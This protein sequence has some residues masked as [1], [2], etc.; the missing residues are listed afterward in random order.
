MAVSISAC[1]SREDPAGGGALAPVD[2]AA[3]LAAL[4]LSRPSLAE[5]RS[6]VDG[7]D[8][9]RVTAALAAYVRARAAAW[10][11]DA[12][13]VPVGAAAAEVLAEA[14]RVARGEVE[15]VGVRH[16]F[17]GA[18]IDWSFN[19]TRDRDGVAFNRQW[20]NHLNRTRFW[21]PLAAAY[22]ATG[23]ERFAAAWAAQL[24]DFLADN[25][26]D[27][28]SDP[29]VRPAW[30]TL[31]TASRMK[32][33]WA[34]LLHAFRDSPSVTDEDLVGALRSFLEHGRHLRANHDGGLDNH[35]AVE[36]RGLHAVGC[37]FPDFRESEDWR[38]HAIATSAA[39]VG[40][41]F[42]PD[43]LSKELSPG[44][45]LLSLEEFWTIVVMSRRFGFEREVDE[46][47]VAALAPAVE[48]TIR[49]S[50]PERTLPSLND[51]GTPDVVAALA[52]KVGVFSCDDALRWLVSDG[53]EG[54]PPSTAS[55]EFD[56]AGLAV[57]RS[58]WAR[59]ATYA[60]F[61]V[62]PLGTDHVH[63]DKLNLVLWAYGRELLFDNGGGSYE[64]S[65]WREF[66]AD[67]R[68][69][70]AALVDGL[71]QRRAR[72]E[73]GDRVSTAPIDA[74]WEAWPDGAVARASYVGEWGD[75]PRADLRPDGLA[76]AEHSREVRYHAPDV[77]VVIDDLR[78]VDGAAHSYEL[79]WNLLST[80]VVVDETTGAVAT[81]DAGLPNLLVVPLGAERPAVTSV[82][83]R[84]GASWRDLA[85]WDLGKRGEPPRPAT[86]VL[87]A[88]EGPGPKRFVTV[89]LALA[90]GTSHEGRVVVDAGAVRVTGAG[91]S[92]TIEVTAAGVDVRR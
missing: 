20:G 43:G 73:K 28:A 63:Q 77:F 50:T 48:A 56:W 46:G 3:L 30:K 1:S 51:S 36:M 16:A 21:R 61:D 69:H 2:D 68:S 90:P 14:D 23:D 29:K 24:R 4:D 52:D 55:H 80:D 42:Y 22:L 41:I 67:T 7:G 38:R 26:F 62:G 47:F 44:Y 74:R 57:M 45:H 66:G 13:E 32:N 70:N 84:T 85:G 33:T 75:A 8:A 87:H 92:T 49:L 89:L 58:G 86:T 31:V 17:P 88:L 39:A 5:V 91:A 54:R 18:D 34:D 78:P 53:A 64:E 11:P 60:V 10:S 6:A 79:R 59:D 12:L 9:A 35:L 65:D 83:A 37:L 81:V 15:L 72:K 76:L 27:P 40:G 71:G 19:A 25:P 82:S